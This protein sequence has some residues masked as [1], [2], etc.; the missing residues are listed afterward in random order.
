MLLHKTKITIAMIMISAM[1]PPA[2]NSNPK[3]NRNATTDWSFNARNADSKFREKLSINTFIV[4]SNVCRVIT[5]LINPVWS[6]HSRARCSLK[7]DA[8]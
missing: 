7:R 2:S 5:A 3:I 1:H 4:T 6:R 8:R